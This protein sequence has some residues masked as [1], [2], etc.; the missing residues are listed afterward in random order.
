MSEKEI[1]W[2]ISSSK[3]K[4]WALKFRWPSGP[5]MAL[6]GAV[7]FAQ[8]IR[9][10]KLTVISSNT[11]PCNEHPGFDWVTIVFDN[12]YEEVK[13]LSDRINKDNGEQAIR[14]GIVTVIQ[15]EA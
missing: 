11:E 5:H 3:G 14:E 6:K 1:N 12:S 4:K 9:Y 7:L 8:V 10:L 15:V 2:L 13:G